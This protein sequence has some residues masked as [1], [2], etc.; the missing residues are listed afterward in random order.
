MSDFVAEQRSHVHDWKDGNLIT[1][2][3]SV[4]VGSGK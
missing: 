4:Y 1:P 3:E 2:T